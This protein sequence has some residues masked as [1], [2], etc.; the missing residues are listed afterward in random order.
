MPADPLPKRVSKPKVEASAED[1]PLSKGNPKHGPEPLV[2]AFQS[3]EISE[4]APK[5]EPHPK[6]ALTPDPVVD[7]PSKVI[8][9]KVERKPKINV[10][11]E[12]SLSN[13]IPKSKV[14]AAVQK[15][16]EK[17]SKK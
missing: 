11:V 13:E 1:K 17:V 7:S 3:M 14:K 2:E 10:P 9:K 5:E 15:I 4:Q 16:E 12:N 6:E 8:L